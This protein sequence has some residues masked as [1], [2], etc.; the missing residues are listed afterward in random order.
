MVKKSG[1][2]LE[3]ESLKPVSRT[4]DQRKQQSKMTPTFL[5]DR[6]DSGDSVETTAGEK[7]FFFFFPRAEINGKKKMKREK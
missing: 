3:L 6:L 2:F 5:A 4:E 7:G 1:C